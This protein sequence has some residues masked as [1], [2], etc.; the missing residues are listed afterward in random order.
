[1]REMR[2]GGM[3]GCEWDGWMESERNH[4]SSRWDGG[5]WCTTTLLH[6]AAA[7]TLLSSFFFSSVDTVCSLLTSLSHS[8]H[9]FLCCHSH[10][11]RYCMPPPA[12]CSLKGHDTTTTTTPTRGGASSLWPDTRVSCAA[13][14]DSR[15]VRRIPLAC[16]HARLFGQQ[17]IAASPQNG[18]QEFCPTQPMIFQCFLVPTPHHFP[19]PP[20]PPLHTPPNGPDWG[21]APFV[22]LRPLHPATL[23]QGN[24]YPLPPLSFFLLFYSTPPHTSCLQ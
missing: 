9:S 13:W 16:G 19:L 10:S 2:N 5:T 15:H 8:H 12:C 22:F 24:E 1:V 3:D 23:P 6:A 11:R 20:L 14:P 18:P 4:S 7:L 21:L 17:R